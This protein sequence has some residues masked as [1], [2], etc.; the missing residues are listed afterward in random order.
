M[1]RP[2]LD[3]SLF[4]WA[5]VIFYFVS[6]WIGS[7]ITYI[8]VRHDI[9]FTLT[10]LMVADYISGII[11]AWKLKIEVTSK[12]SNKGIIEKI[13]LLAI[14]MSMGMV[15]K[16][17]NI[18]IGITIQSVFTILIVA[19]LYSFIGNCYCIYTGKDVKEFD[20]V[21]YILRFIKEIVLKFLKSLLDG[22]K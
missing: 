10:I 5:K 16:V 3:M 17:V 18:P 2:Q 13:T 9:V 19:E 4:G 20:A 7:C 22:K 15:F 11:K 21:T 1:E 6:L 12:R 8:G 14:P